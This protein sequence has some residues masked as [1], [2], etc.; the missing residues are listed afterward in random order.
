[1]SYSAPGTGRHDGMNHDR[2][3]SDDS[4]TA[5]PLEQPQALSLESVGNY[6]S[7]KRRVP[8]DEKP[9]YSEAIDELP[10][11]AQAHGILDEFRLAFFYTWSDI[12]KRPRNT[13]IGFAATLIVVLVTGLILMGIGKSHVIF[14][15]FAELT[16]GEM[17]A[18]ILAEGGVPFVNYTDLQP[19]LALSTRTSGTAPRWLAKGEVSRIPARGTANDVRTTATNVLVIDSTVEKSIGIGRAFDYRSIGFSETQVLGSLLKYLGVYA[20]VGDRARV[21][22]DVAGTLGQQGVQ[23]PIGG[24]AGNVPIINQT[25]ATAAAAALQQF[26]EAN[27]TLNIPGIGNVST[28]AFF[29]NTNITAAVDTFNG[30]IDIQNAVSGAALTD[31]LSPEAKFVVADGFSGPLGK[32]PGSLGNMALLDYR[33]LIDMLLEQ[34]CYEAL[35]N[36][37]A[38]TGI[39]NIPGVQPVVP[40]LP[41]SAEIQA[42]FR[43]SDYVLVVVAMLE[44]RF[45][46]Y[47]KT[48]DARDADMIEWSNDLFYAIGIDFGGSAEYPIAIALVGFDQFALFLNSVFTVCVIVIVVLGALLVYTLLLTNAEERGFE[49][50]M[51]RAQGMTKRQLFVLMLVQMLAF[52]L[53]GLI[54]AMALIL[55][56]NA[57]AEVALTIYTFAPA[58]TARISPEAIVVPLLVGIFVPILGNAGPVRAALAQSLRDAL[59]IYRNKANETTVVATRLAEIGMDPFTV[60]MAWLLVVVGFMVYYLVPLAFIFNELWLFFLVMNIILIMMLF[61]LCLMSGTIQ[62]FLERGILW[63]LLWGREKRL[64]TL[65]YK[66]FT[67]HSERNSKGFMMFNLSV[68]CLVFGGVLFTLLSSSISQTVSVLTGADVTVTSLVFNTPINRT[69]L[70]VFLADNRA[71]VAAWS[72]ESYPVSDYPQFKSLTSLRNAI[73]FPSS[74]QEFIGLDREFLNAAFGEFV[75]IEDKEGSVPFATSAT[76]AVDIVRSLYDSPPSQRLQPVGPIFTGYP[77]NQTLPDVAAK[78]QL[79]MPS[80]SSSA[81]TDVIGLTAGAFGTISLTYT[82]GNGPSQQEIDT[83]YLSATRALCRKFPGTLQVSPIPFTFRGS[84]TFITTDDFAALL[85]SN[86]IDYP[87]LAQSA[88]ITYTADDATTDVLYRKLYVRLQ[89]SL[90]EDERTFFVNLLQSRVNPYYHLTVDTKAVVDSVQSA[91]DL[92]ITFFYVVAAIAI[93]LDTL[94]LWLTF[95]SNVQLNSWSFAVLRSLGFTLKQLQRAFIYESMSLVLSGFICG[96]IIGVTIAITL[97]LQLNLFLQL[98]FQ[99]AFPYGLFFFLLGLSIVSAVIAPIIPSRE[100]SRRPIASVLKGG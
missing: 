45:E 21:Y 30:I 47:Y 96:T 15:R 65:I 5:R 99:F 33:P 16:T 91:G 72:Y 64:K 94:M 98:P 14:L 3:S 73:G 92:I 60:M 29:A 69:E 50:A 10:P 2:Q 95:V 81:A 51:L 86:V 75:L 61:G 56:L 76:G 38:A 89:P 34:N 27:P 66:N 88:V 87:E 1:M 100:I 20:N 7:P 35:R 44:S 70:D 74:P 18:L 58:Y 22:I 42:T 52:V 83:V 53:P 41:S 80:I 79:I 12:K 19:K 23:L 93:V 13:A 26:I 55:A 68:A 57:I 82:V 48:Q 17:D 6:T 85:R 78:Y 37:L 24:I 49:V 4:V 8:L 31:F 67:S 40:G 63:M 84:P 59:D 25:N 97:V 71:S 36:P 11:Y 46:T 90:G 9:D 62:V 32:Y 39:N 77:P 28:A 54:L 43:L